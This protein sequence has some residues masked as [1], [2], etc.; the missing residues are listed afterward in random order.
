MRKILQAQMRIVFAV[1]ST[2]QNSYGNLATTLLARQIA[3]RGVEV[4]EVNLANPRHPDILQ[5]LKTCHLLFSFNG[6]ALVRAYRGTY[7][8]R[9]L[10]AKLFCAFGDHPFYKWGDGSWSTLDDAYFGFNDLLHAELMAA[11]FPSWHGRIS[12]FPHYPVFPIGRKTNQSCSLAEKRIFFAGTAKIMSRPATL[13]PD[14]IFLSSPYTKAYRTLG[15]VARIRDEEA[16]FDFQIDRFLLSLP[17]SG[18]NYLHVIADMFIE[19]DL[20]LRAVRRQ[21]L[22]SWLSAYP[23]TVVGDGWEQTSI[24]RM[25]NVELLPWMAYATLETDLRLKYQIGLH[26]TQNQHQAPHDRIF[27]IA[28]AGQLLLTT[29]TCYTR[30]LPTNA[31]VSIHRCEKHLAV[32]ACETALTA[33]IESYADAL[34]QHFASSSTEAI[35]RAADSIISIAMA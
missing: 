26:I 11:V 31:K 5:R 22:L 4:V 24:S 30:S 10:G 6:R 13:T 27:N 25:P 1:K 7:L 18:P 35:A 32:A 34:R 21:R 12:H 8:H 23:L 14:D 3:E 16:N 28:H 19:C 9:L 2:A 17:F 20:Y 33:D 29:E 15:V